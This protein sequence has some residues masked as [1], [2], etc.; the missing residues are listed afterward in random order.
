MS[1]CVVEDK[2]LEL[3]RLKEMFKDVEEKHKCEV[4]RLKT[5]LHRMEVEE[6]RMRTELENAKKTI[7]RMQAVLDAIHVLVADVG[8]ALG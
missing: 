4:Y 5:E 8:G 1:E 6:A 3:T 7:R 2:T